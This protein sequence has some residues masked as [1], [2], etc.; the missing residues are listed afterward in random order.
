M[1]SWYYSKNGVQLG[2]V[3]EDEFRAKIAA[4]E[5][6]PSDMVWK[7]GMG[8]WQQLAQVGELRAT[9]AM[10]ASPPGMT[11]QPPSYQTPGGITAPIP[12][13]LWQSIVVTL[14]CCMPLRVVGI[15]FAAKVDGLQARGDIA[16]AM[17]AS[18]SAKTWALVG[19][20]SGLVV[21][22]GYLLLVF[23]IGLA[24]AM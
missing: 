13:Y 16:G 6:L 10:M 1:N 20:I 2:P 12:N 23:T 9:G 14:F 5:V 11:P 7:E 15:V 18:K 22:V 24:G 21:I 3:G 4:G 19:F 17:D 8:D